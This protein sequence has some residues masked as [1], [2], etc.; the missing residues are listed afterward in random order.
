MKQVDQA[1]KGFQTLLDAGKL[2]TMPGVPSD[3]ARIIAATPIP[4]LV[5]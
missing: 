4:G 3:L 5:G 1:R 2:R